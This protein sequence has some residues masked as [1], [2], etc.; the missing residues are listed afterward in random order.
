MAMQARSSLRLK[1]GCVRDDADDDIALKS[2]LHDY[3]SHHYLASCSAFG[4]LY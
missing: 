3:P 4:H 2:K 1:N